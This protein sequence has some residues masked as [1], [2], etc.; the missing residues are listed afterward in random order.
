[1]ESC[2]TGAFNQFK[3][4]PAKI[5]P[6]VRA[7]AGNQIFISLLLVVWAG[8]LEEG[9]QIALKRRRIEYIIVN[10]V[11][12]KNKIKITQLVG[13]KRAVSKIKSFE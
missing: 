5:A 1:M 13:L 6:K 2:V 7:V 9:D 4:E 11:A 8:S 10:I 12:V 3:E